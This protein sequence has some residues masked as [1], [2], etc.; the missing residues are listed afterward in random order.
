MSEFD[1]KQIHPTVSV[2]SRN[3]ETMSLRSNK[4]LTN[5]FSSCS[6]SSASRPESDASDPTMGFAVFGSAILIDPGHRSIRSD[7]TRD[8]ST[9]QCRPNSSIQFRGVTPFGE[10]PAM[11]DKK[12]ANPLKRL[13]HHRC[14]PATRKSRE[15]DFLRNCEGLSAFSAHGDRRTRIRRPRHL[16]TSCNS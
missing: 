1:P 4:S 5:L 11:R 3:G 14:A 8:E 12:P 6:F 2:E 10:Q 16:I 13:T 7:S 9:K 15:S